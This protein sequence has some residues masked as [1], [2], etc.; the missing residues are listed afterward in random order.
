LAP[1]WSNLLGNQPAY[2]TADFLAGINRNSFSLDLFVDNAF[3]RRAQLYRYAECPVF[4]PS[5]SGTPTTLGTPLCG[6]HPYVG[7][8]TPRMVGLRFGQKF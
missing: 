8:N 2:G 3:D 7:I 1:A 6:L 5:A 4:S